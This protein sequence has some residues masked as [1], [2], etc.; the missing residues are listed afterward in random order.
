MINITGVNLTAIA[1]PITA[2]RIPPVNGR[3]GK[4]M[5]STNIP[6]M[7]LYMIL[8]SVINRMADGAAVIP[9][10]G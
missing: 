4:L 5:R 7:I 9:M 10:I 1:S 2:L 6:K 3:M 8:G